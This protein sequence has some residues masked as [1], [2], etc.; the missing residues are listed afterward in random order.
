MRHAIM[1]HQHNHNNI[2]NALQEAV[3]QQNAVA[4]WQLLRQAQQQQLAAGDGVRLNTMVDVIRFACRGG[5]YQL[6]TTL[7]QQYDPNAILNVRD[8]QSGSGQT[9]LHHA[10]DSGH[11]SIVNALLQSLSPRGGGRRA[12]HH[13]T[14]VAAIINAT[15]TQ[16][17]TALDIAVTR[18]DY[19]IVNALL[20]S[21]AGFNAA[22]LC[23]AINSYSILSALLR[24]CL[25]TATVV[26]GRDAQGWTA[27]QRAVM[28]GTTRDYSI[29]SALLRNG[30]DVNARDPQGFTV[31]HREMMMGDGDSSS[32]RDYSIICSM[33]RAGGDVNAQDPQGLT[34]LHHAMNGG[35]RDYNII[36]CLLRG[37]GANVNVTDL[38][39]M[40]AL[41]LHA[42]IGSRHDDDNRD[43]A[44][45]ELLRNFR[46]IQEQFE[47]NLLRILER[48]LPG[49]GI[50][51]PPRDAEVGDDG[52][53]TIVAALLQAGANV[54]A[55]DQRGAVPLTYASSAGHLPI[56]VAL[57]QAGA[58][59]NGGLDDS[60]AGTTTAAPLHVA[61]AA[62]HVEI[63]EALLQAGANPRG[64]D[65]E[66]LTALHHAAINGHLNLIFSLLVRD[67]S[68]VED[69]V[70]RRRS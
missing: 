24:S 63:V 1:N 37:R 9:A 31:L 14:H 50:Q 19:N 32:T 22:T 66:G 48:N 69:L 11:Y 47:R 64:S 59:V 62:G 35:D 17:R 45:D 29:I 8:S 68:Q 4:V 40:T 49:M 30:A 60:Q 5:H 52:D 16:N 26:N 65:R 51:I 61:S 27:L 38:Q 57:L 44:N 36:R 15:D 53:R 34:A 7:L 33:I 28:V 56:V 54:N 39:G 10:V 2:D 18:G 70:S 67:P 41:H 21:G 46:A 13:H 58:N 6:V 3:A 23:N 25:P 12:Y 20:R 42:M 43:A 55:M